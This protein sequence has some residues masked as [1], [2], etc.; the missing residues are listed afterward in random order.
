MTNIDF[1][2]ITFFLMS[3]IPWAFLVWLNTTIGSQTIWDLLKPYITQHIEQAVVDELKEV[4][5]LVRTENM[6]TLDD[7]M[8]ACFEGR[9]KALTSK[10]GDTNE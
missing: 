5:R 2:A 10:A 9:I 3:A 1:A 6:D 8:T 4:L 7:S